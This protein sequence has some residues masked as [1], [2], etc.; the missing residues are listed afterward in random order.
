VYYPGWVAEVDGRR[1]EV[2]R[3][4]YAFR[5]VF[6]SEGS[7]Q[8]RFSFQPVT[9][10]VGLGCSLITWA[11]LAILTVRALVSRWRRR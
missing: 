4:N 6:L 9:W 11:V 1:A 7:H 5:A 8:V 3:A 10:K 2:L